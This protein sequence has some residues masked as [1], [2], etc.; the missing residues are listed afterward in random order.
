MTQHFWHAVITKLRFTAPSEPG[1]YPVSFLKTGC[2]TSD[3]E[4][5]ELAASYVNG[6]VTILTGGTTATTKATEA[7]TTTTKKDIPSGLTYSIG[8]VTNVEPGATV[9]VPVTVSGDPGS[10]GIVLQFTFDNALAFT[11]RV[12]GD[13]YEGEP[14]W[15]KEDY[16]FVWHSSNG[17]NV[18]AEDD[19]VIT[20][21]R[22][23]APTTPGKYPVSF[24]KTGCST[25]DQEGV[26][27]AATYVDGFVTVLGTVI[28]SS[29]QDT[30]ATT[31]N[32]T[33]TK[34][35]EETTTTTTTSSLTPDFGDVNL[36][37]KVSVADAV[38][39]NRAIAGT[40]DLNAQAKLNADCKFDKTLNT[41]DSLQIMRYLVH[42][43]EKSVLGQA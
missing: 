41:D 11:R 8:N 6:S 1:Q 26:E 4:G 5:V 23:T 2:S 16:T 9:D 29:T 42:L 34:Q 37:G 43:I 17:R 25:S 24:L 7:S 28:T 3:Q 13:A 39:L 32:T 38:L 20:K 21:L 12:S 36:D 10:G 31:S 33:T 40:A 27:I 18:K 19:A 15:N 22:F 35:Q 14:T 30:T